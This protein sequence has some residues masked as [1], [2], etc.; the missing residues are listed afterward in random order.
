MLTSGISQLWQGRKPAV[1]AQ[2]GRLPYDA[3]HAAASKSCL[4]RWFRVPIDHSIRLTRVESYVSTIARMDQQLWGRYHVG[5]V[6]VYCFRYACGGASCV[7]CEPHVLVR[8]FQS[9]IRLITTS[10]DYDLLR[11]STRY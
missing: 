3:L 5:E 7:G 11:T 10:G 4:I 2:T 6:V 1:S 8:Q 9:T